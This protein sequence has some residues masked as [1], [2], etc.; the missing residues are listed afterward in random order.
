MKIRMGF[1]ANSSSSSFTIALPADFQPTVENVRQFFF[2]AWTAKEKKVYAAEYNSNAMANGYDKES[3]EQLI[4]RLCQELSHMFSNDIKPLKIP[5]AGDIYT[6]PGPYVSIA[7]LLF[8][9]VP[10]VENY[11]PNDF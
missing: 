3:P 9:N 7:E 8:Q 10:Y 11:F 4:E 5:G 2:G 6:V 1:V